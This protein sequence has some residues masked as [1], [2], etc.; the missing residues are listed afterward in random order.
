MPPR[1][2]ASRALHADR[3]DHRIRTATPR[4]VTDRGGEIVH[5]PEVHGGDRVPPRHGQSFV[6]QIDA[7]HGPGPPV[8]GDPRAHLPD[9]PESED[10]RGTAGRNLR[11]LDPLPCGRH[12]IRKVEVPFVRFAVVGD[13][14][15]P[16]ICM[17]N[18]QIFGL[19][20]RNLSV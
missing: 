15:R 4:E 10:H 8:S 7:D 11:I 9:R 20:A 16:D 2:L 12:D 19:R 3:V 18:P 6:D 14:D 17:R 5:L 1:P 13:D